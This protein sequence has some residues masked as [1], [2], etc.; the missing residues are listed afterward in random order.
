MDDSPS[1]TAFLKPRW[2][3]RSAEKY[4]H[5]TPL[6]CLPGILITGIH[7]HPSGGK[8]EFTTSGKKNVTDAWTVAPGV[9]ATPTRQFPACDGSD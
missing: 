4:F 1:L 8:H 2:R 3:R 9:Y 6:V 7:R 5:G